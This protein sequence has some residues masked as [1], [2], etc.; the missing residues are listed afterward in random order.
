VAGELSAGVPG[1]TG[2][3][4]TLEVHNMGL[5][6]KG[7]TAEDLTIALVVPGGA[8]VV[9]T[10]GAGYQGVRMDPQ[11]KAS[12]AV[13]QL[14]RLGPKDQQQYT[15]TLSQA[16]TQQDNV[17][18]QVRWTKPAVKGAPSDQANIGPAPLQRATQ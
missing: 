5:R 11:L 13:W 9:S 3:T 17:R 8:K 2:V 6:G 14:G 18:G 12:V 10:T 15:I 1:A 4:Y 16:G 7:L